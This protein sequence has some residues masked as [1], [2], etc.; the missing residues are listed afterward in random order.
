MRDRTRRRNYSAAGEEFR[1][2]HQ[3]RREWGLRQRHARKL[4]RLRRH[5]GDN[6][7]GS[8]LLP[9]DSEVLLQ[10]TAADD[11]AREQVASSR[12][13]GTVSDPVL[14][15]QQ[16][17]TPDPPR[18]SRSQVRSVQDQG[19]RP[20]SRAASRACFCGSAKGEPSTRKP[21]ARSVFVAGSACR[22]P[23]GSGGPRATNCFRAF[24]LMC[25]GGDGWRER[26]LD[27]CALGVS[28]EFFDCCLVVVAVNF[29]AVGRC[30]WVQLVM[31]WLRPGK[32]KNSRFQQWERESYCLSNSVLAGPAGKVTGHARLV[33]WASGPGTGRGLSGP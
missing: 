28:D 18:T 2:E 26:V 20:G 13:P 8:P 16:A 29:Y 22:E 5:G 12:R 32:Y 21:R 30:G 31:L 14:R 27:G 19:V 3:R 7:L 1:R 24:E 10:V 6:Y 4:S 23:G 15:R 17:R 33:T 9:C 25:G 11:S